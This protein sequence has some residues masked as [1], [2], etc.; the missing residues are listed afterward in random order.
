MQQKAPAAK[1]SLGE[2]QSSEML[3]PQCPYSLPKV[4]LPSFPHP[5]NPNC[6][7]TTFTSIPT[8]KLCMCLYSGFSVGLASSPASFYELPCHSL[9]SNQALPKQKK[10]ITFWR[11]RRFVLCAVMRTNCDL[12][13]TSKTDTL[14]FGMNI[15][16][17]FTFSSLSFKKVKSRK[18]QNFNCLF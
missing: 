13:K 12:L 11:L 9:H 3:L 4:M 6:S 14:S 5:G 15:G 1:V 16:N 17:T 8:W 2:G 18:K 10:W 7:H